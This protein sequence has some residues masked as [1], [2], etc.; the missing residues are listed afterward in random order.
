MCSGVSA[1]VRANRKYMAQVRFPTM[2]VHEA[3]TV[4]R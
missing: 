4:E 1:E 2:P 3:I